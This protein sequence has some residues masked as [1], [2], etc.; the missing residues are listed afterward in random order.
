MSV[1]VSGCVC[2]SEASRGHGVV[3]VDGIGK[4]IALTWRKQGLHVG[5]GSMSFS[6]GCA[7]CEGCMPSRDD[8]RGAWRMVLVSEGLC[9]REI[10]KG[11][12]GC[13]AWCADL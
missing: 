1:Q 7:L 5:V 3:G 12:L 9:S 4:S 10:L 2:V 8:V 11:G 6:K 13:I